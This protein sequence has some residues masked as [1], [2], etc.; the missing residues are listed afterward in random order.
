MSQL[1]DIETLSSD[2]NRLK[3]EYEQY[4]MRVLKREPLTLRNDIDRRILIYSNKNLSNTALKFRLNSM[5]A[6]YNTYKQYW[7]RTLR[8]IEEGTYT[9]RTEG[10]GGAGTVKAKRTVPA[11]QTCTDPVEKAY[12]EYIETRKQQNESVKGLNFEKFSKNL[13]ASKKKVEQKYKTKEVE[14]KVSVKD[15]KTRLTLRPKKKG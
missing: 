6:K 11:G 14:V 10:S 3:I 2:I 1:N 9:R 7:V 15:G 13:E 12:R 5:V 8:A 4:F